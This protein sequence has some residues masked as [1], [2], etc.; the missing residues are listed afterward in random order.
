[1][2]KTK[3]LIV[4]DGAIGK[5][6]LL[7]RF[8][9]E[10]IDW[11]SEEPEYEPTTFNNF[12]LSWESDEHGSLEVEMWDTAGQEAFEQ[13]RK[14]SYPGTDIYLVGYSTTSSISLNNIE[15]K[16]IPEITENHTGDDKPWLILVGTKKDIRDGVTEEAAKEAAKKINACALVD[17]SAKDPDENSSGIHALTDMMMKLAFKKI[18]GEPRPDWGAFE[19]HEVKA[20]PKSEVKT[21]PAPAP[22]GEGPSDVKTGPCPPAEPKAAAPAPKKEAAPPKGDSSEPAKGGDGCKCTIM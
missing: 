16:W 18:K 9:N 14:L 15:H 12:V 13:L 4:G 10:S 7:N 22:V 20:P 3:A 5:T 19:A 2:E 8:T 11:E 1:V 17:T 21:A 6:C